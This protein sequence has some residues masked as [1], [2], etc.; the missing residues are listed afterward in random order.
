MA[1]TILMP[2][3]G[4]TVESC[5]LSEWLI[6]EGDHIQLG[7][8]LFGYETDKATFT[9]ESEDEGTVLK[10]LSQEG[11]IVPV[12]EPVLIVGKPGET[13]TELIPDRTKNPESDSH[14][15]AQTASEK[16]TPIPT[17]SVPTSSGSSSGASPRAKRLA[18]RRGLDLTDV[19]GTG[20]NGRQIE[21][22]VQTA[23]MNRHQ[24]AS[25]APEQKTSDLYTLEP[26]SNIRRLIG[27]TMSDSLAHSAQLTHT[28]SYDATAVLSYH[29][30]LKKEAETES[31]PRITLNDILIYAVSR[32]LQKHRELN[33]HFIDNS[34]AY[35]HHVEMGIATDTPR[36][37]MVPT[38]HRAELLPLAE[39]AQ[40]AKELT[41]QA[42]SGKI[43]PDLLK[44]GSFTISN[45]GTLDIEHFTPIIN[46]PQTG[47]LGVNTI[48]TRVRLEAGIP[49]FYPAMGLSLTYDHRALDGAQASRFLKDLKLYLEQFPTQIES[50]PIGLK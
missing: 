36:G 49:V 16:S 41:S 22:D 5:Y 11:D 23:L 42:I 45:L 9:Y 44:N 12:L 18:S 31:L 20:P 27:K 32:V 26:L 2:K 33:A 30:K 14:V 40:K 10:L 19:P 38:L 50:D 13:F 35:F 47:I 29:A 7:T 6:K 25:H 46:P 15:P 39:I 17:T 37:L 43:D 34:I 48:T 8:P 28:L 3:Q 21:R 24:P 1:K 4:N